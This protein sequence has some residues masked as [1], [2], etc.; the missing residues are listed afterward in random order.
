MQRYKQFSTFLQIFPKFS[1]KVFNRPFSCLTCHFRHA[2][3]DRAS[4]VLSEAKILK[5]QKKRLRILQKKNNFA[6][7]KEDSKSHLYHGFE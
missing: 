3:H 7:L 6:P 2:R 1:T 4:V 5:K